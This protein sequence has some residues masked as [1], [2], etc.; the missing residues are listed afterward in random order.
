MK[1]YKITKKNPHENNKT[2]AICYI[3]G[4]FSHINLVNPRLAIEVVSEFPGMNY[5]GQPQ[6]SLKA[7]VPSFRRASL[8]GLWDSHREFELVQCRTVITEAGCRMQTCL[9]GKFIY[10]KNATPSDSSCWIT[11]ATKSGTVFN[12]DN[13][14]FYTP[15]Q[16]VKR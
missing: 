14:R 4:L 8:P 2:R 5:K 6:N 1:K 11:R 16:K 10:F 13:A 15:R 9:G 3:A 12:L 7:S